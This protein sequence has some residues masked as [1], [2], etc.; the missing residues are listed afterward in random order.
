MKDVHSDVTTG[1]LM[2]LPVYRSY[3]WCTDVITDVIA[4]V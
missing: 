2:L 1:V 3:Y 4:L